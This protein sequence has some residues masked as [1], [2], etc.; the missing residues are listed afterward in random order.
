MNLLIATRKLLISIFQKIFGYCGMCGQW[1][2]Y[3]KRRRQN[4]AYI[5]DEYNY[6]TVCSECF[7][8]V[9]AYWEECWREYNGS[10]GC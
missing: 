4:T 10:R 1:F 6:I 7:E 9:E 8:R 3:P 5:D 2:V